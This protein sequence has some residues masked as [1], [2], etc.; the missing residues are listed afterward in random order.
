M[1]IKLDELTQLAHDQISDPKVR[2]E[3]LKAA[4]ALEKEKKNDR[5]SSPK[6][7]SDKQWV[8]VLKG[9]AQ[10]DVTDIVGH[11]FQLPE[12]EDA[13]ALIT[14]VGEAAVEH[15]LAT[16]KRS[17]L[18]ETFDDVVHI[19][20]RALKNKN[21]ALKSKMDWARVIQLPDGVKFGGFEKTREA[22]E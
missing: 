9:P 12:E 11:V 20:P 17:N 2:E 14:K 16:K 22:S 6:S 19:K 7:K 1:S 3:F 4:E 21:V 18:V 15:N 5:I 13:A 8:V 10:I